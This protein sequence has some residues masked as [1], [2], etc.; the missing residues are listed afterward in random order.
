MFSHLKVLQKCKI[1]NYIE[2]NPSQNGCHQGKAC[3]QGGEGERDFYTC[4]ECKL[5]QPLW[6][7]VWGGSQKTKSRPS[8]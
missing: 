3:W 1:K 6:K 2:I 5:V 7:S 4:W 8:I